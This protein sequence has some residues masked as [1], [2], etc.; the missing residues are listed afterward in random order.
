MLDR[1]GN[2]LKKINILFFVISDLVNT[3]SVLIFL[4]IPG[5]YID[6]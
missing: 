3:A 4:K 1:K 6:R 5:L 2:I